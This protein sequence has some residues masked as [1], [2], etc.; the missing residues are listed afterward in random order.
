MAEPRIKDQRA[1]SANAAEK[2]GWPK[3]NERGYELLEQAYGI[4]VPKR[5][6]VIGAGATGKCFAK[7]TE[8]LP[9]LDVQIYEK[10]DDV[11]GM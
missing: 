10:N 1:Y 2:H 9:G 8:S 3:V 7:F 4:S 6:I 5:V 11:S